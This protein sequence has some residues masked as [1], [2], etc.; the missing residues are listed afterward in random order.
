MLTKES[1]NHLQD[2]MILAG[3]LQDKVSFE[4]LVDNSF[5]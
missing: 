2:I 5:N 1:F 3:E 4:D